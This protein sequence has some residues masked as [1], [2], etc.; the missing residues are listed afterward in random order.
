MK[1]KDSGFFWPSFTDL[2]TS[3]FFIM[4]VLYVLT[5]IKLQSELIKSEKE[6]RATEKELNKI[7]EIEKALKALPSEYFTYDEKYKKHILN[8]EVKF[9]GGSSNMNDMNIDIR[10]KIRDA[11]KKIEKVLKDLYKKDARI[12]YLLV[13]EGQAS[14]DTYS[15]NDVL[16]Y[17]RAI[18]LRNFW[19]DKGGDYA[20]IYNNKLGPN[21]EVVIAGSGQYGVPRDLPDVP[22]KNQRFLITIIPKIGELK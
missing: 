17:N 8:V 10:S 9:N 18:A 3:L 15:G 1:E 7:K 12:Q 16:S 4:L 2:M 13:I 14:K 20:S 11:G 19:F 22:P 5:F 6:K 21:T